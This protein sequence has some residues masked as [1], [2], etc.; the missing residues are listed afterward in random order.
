[1]QFISKT[2]FHGAAERLFTLG[3]ISGVLWKPAGPAPVR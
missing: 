2:S 1:M 3:G